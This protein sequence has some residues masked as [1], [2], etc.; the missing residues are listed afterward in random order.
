MEIQL[1]DARRRRNLAGQGRV[2]D[3]TPTA[4]EAEVDVAGAMATSFDDFMRDTYGD[5]ITGSQA[6][7]QYRKSFASIMASLA[8]IGNQSGN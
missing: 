8:A 6:D 2:G 4:L 1:E 7:A 3:F 5:V